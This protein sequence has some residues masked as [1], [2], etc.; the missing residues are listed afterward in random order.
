MPE[1]IVNEEEIDNPLKYFSINA[2]SWDYITGEI[3]EGATEKTE[4]EFE[5]WKEEQKAIIESGELNETVLTPDE[6]L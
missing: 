6:D 5:I 4:E 2:N 1:Q 3:P